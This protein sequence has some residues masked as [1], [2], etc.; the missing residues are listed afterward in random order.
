MGK[1][2]SFKVDERFAEA[3]HTWAETLGAKKSVV[4]MAALGHFM[5]LP[6]DERERV[7]REQVEKWRSSK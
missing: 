2:L 4:V 1:V 7:T 5:T 3:F 6:A